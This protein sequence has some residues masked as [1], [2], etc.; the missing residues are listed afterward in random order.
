[1][2]DIRE[3]LPDTFKPDHSHWSSIRNEVSEEDQ[4][5]SREWLEGK[6]KEF[7]SQV[8]LCGYFYQQEG[9]YSDYLRT[10]NKDGIS[11]VRKGYIGDTKVYLYSG[12]SASKSDMELGKILEVLKET[13]KSEPGKLSGE[14]I[15]FREEV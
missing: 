8:E 7:I 15:W 9:T 2:A 10:G 3:D 5:K 11:D 14:T 12:R 13:W 4:K 6:A 1:M